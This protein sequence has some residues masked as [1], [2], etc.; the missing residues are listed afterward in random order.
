[1]FTNLTSK[2]KQQQQQNQTRLY[3]IIV[4][5][6]ILG[7]FMTLQSYQVK[8]IRS[9]RNDAPT[10]SNLQ[11]NESNRGNNGREDENHQHPGKYQFDAHRM[12]LEWASQPGRGYTPTR[13][14]TW[15]PEM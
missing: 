7:G 12:A 3:G 1:M 10:T 9:S 13:H 2:V 5:G 11:E 8:Q 14:E 15:L 4:V 6:F